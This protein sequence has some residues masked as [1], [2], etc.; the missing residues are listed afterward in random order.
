VA[1]S[2]EH[3]NEQSGFLEGEFLEQENDWV[4]FFVS[5]LVGH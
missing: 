4:K 5:R 2:Y 1:V 3:G